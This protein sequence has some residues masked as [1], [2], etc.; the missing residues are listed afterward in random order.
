MDFGMEGLWAT[1]C[2]LHLLSFGLR[3]FVEKEISN[4]TFVGGVSCLALSHGLL[5]L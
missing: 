2:V 3:C 4:F 5:S 1:G